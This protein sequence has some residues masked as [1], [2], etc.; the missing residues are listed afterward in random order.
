VY[1]PRSF[2]ESRFNLPHLSDRMTAPLREVRRQETRKAL[3]QAAEEVLAARGLSEARVEEIAERA[4]V[5]VGTIY[6]YFDA[7]DGL[8]AALLET[9]REELQARINALAKAKRPFPQQVEALARAVFEHFDE[10]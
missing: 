9:R 5:S 10:N 6:N 1:N 4:G 7:R 3:L 8:V 2:S